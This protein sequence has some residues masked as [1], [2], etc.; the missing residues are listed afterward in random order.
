MKAN[1]SDTPTL[2]NETKAPRRQK[3]GTKAVRK[4]AATKRAKPTRGKAGSR[5]AGR[6]DGNGYSATASRLLSQGREALGGAY[7]WAADGAS[8]AGRALPRV[9]YDRLPDQR[10]M[11]SF[12]ED[13]PL[14]LGAIGLGI[15]AM[16][17][18]MLPARLMSMGSAAKKSGPRRGQRRASRKSR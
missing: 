8:R 6:Q 5:K 2:G 11:Q 7:E 9:P 16:I 14:V 18:M 4:N 3:R 17:G 1:D 15:G 13:R 12:I 10:A